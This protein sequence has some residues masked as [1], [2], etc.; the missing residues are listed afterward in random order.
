MRTRWEEGMGYGMAPS[1]RW[2]KLSGLRP[3]L[4]V[5]FAGIGVYDG[6]FDNRRCEVNDEDC[7]E[8]R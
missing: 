7:I 4:D 1:I 6:C 3:L 8:K 2:K 5:Q